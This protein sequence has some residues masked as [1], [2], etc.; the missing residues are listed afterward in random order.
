M[1]VGI[2]AAVLGLLIATACIAIPRVVS[3]RNDP[4]NR[5][6]A[7]AYENQTGRS[8]RDIEQGNAAVR[9]RQQNSSGQQSG[10][11]A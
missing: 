6:D 1:A 9:A 5:A 7:L 3:R 8:A 11:D 4:Y 2:L 10:T